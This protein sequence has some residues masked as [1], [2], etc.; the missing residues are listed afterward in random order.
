MEEYEGNWRP[1]I[2]AVGRYWL[3]GNVPRA[4]EK[5]KAEKGLDVGCMEDCT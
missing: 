2:L 3:P 4:V 1:K 5:R